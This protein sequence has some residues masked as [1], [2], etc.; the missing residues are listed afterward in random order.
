MEKLIHLRNA[1]A[2]LLDFGL[3]PSFRLRKMGTEFLDLRLV[4][5]FGLRKASVE[6]RGL[7]FVPGF[8]LLKVGVEL[9]D[10]GLVTGFCLRKE[11]AL[12]MLDPRN[13]FWNGSIQAA[14]R[15]GKQ[16]GFSRFRGLESVAN[17]SLC[18]LCSSMDWR[19]D[20]LAN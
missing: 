11:L 6:F 2:E 16:I 1:I 3:V 8:G 9:L 14:D 13:P 20:R 19:L 18:S 15:S 4:P 10:F 17:A 5:S 12:E 7:R